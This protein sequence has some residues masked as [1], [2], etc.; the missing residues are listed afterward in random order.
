LRRKEAGVGDGERMAH[1]NEIIMITGV[2][3]VAY[4]W[5]MDL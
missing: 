1:P 3:G 5:M 4:P 2:Y